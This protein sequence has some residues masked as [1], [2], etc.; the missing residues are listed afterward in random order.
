MAR[1]AFIDTET[2]GLDPARNEIIEI[3]LKIIDT[4]KVNKEFYNH[5]HSIVQR[6]IV[7]WLNKTENK[8][9]Y[10]LNIIL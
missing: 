3:A 4:E 5:Q 1:L 7:R 2:T 8:R 10:N 6:E 9:A